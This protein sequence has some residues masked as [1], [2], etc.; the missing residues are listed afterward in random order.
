MPM[1]AHSPEPPSHFLRTYSETPKRRHIS[2]SRRPQSERP[3]ARPGALP[4]HAG[5]ARDDQQPLYQVQ[6][7][8]DLDT[9]HVD[10]SEASTRETLELENTDLSMQSI[11]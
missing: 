7:H 9:P 8:Y 11:V 4:L 1:L 6:S 2:R 10:G 3:A 5:H